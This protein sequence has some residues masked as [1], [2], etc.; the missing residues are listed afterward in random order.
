MRQVQA[1]GHAALAAHAGCPAG[2]VAAGGHV[3]GLCS[4]GGITLSLPP[5]TMALRCACGAALRCAIPGPGAPCPAAP[6]GG[7]RPGEALPPPGAPNA[8]HGGKLANHKPD[9]SLEWL[10]RASSFLSP[11][12]LHQGPLSSLHCAVAR[13][14]I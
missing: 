11:L 9:S 6:G 2:G 3:G 8:E 12:L 4:T 7:A 1:C 5:I 10:R 13:T 14:N